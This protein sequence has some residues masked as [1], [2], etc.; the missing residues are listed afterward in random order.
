M[1]RNQK[2]S[3]CSLLI[4]G[5]VIIIFIPVFFIGGG[6]ETWA[7]DRTRFIISAAVFA[8]GY[9]S[10]FTMLAL[11]RNK[12]S[13][14]IE[15]DE[16]DI[17]IGRKASELT[18]IIVMGYIFFTCI[19]LYTLYE[20]TNSVPAGWMWFIGYTCIFTG[21]IAN[22]AINLILYKSKADIL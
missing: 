6:A 22:S 2:R 4:W 19:I 1:N 12:K 21:Y 13:G 7:L 9:I 3:L 10:F 17:L 14:D 5:I 11:T 20:K 8:A 16:R 15:R 18:L